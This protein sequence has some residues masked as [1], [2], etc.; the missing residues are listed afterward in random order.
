MG[1]FP[2]TAPTEDFRNGVTGNLWPEKKF[3][4]GGSSVAMCS[5][6]PG[7]W[8]KSW[9]AVGVQTRLVGCVPDS[10]DRIPRAEYRLGFNRNFST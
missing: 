8:I 1:C 2:A 5:K 10:Q 4:S 9:R 6:L 3:A 7:S